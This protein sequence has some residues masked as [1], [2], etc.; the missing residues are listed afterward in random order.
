M[1]DPKKQRSKYRGPRH[2]WQ[3]E[4]LVRERGYVK[5][6]GLKN[7]KEIYKAV[8][9]A[10][11][12]SKHAKKIIRSVNLVQAERETKEFIDRLQRFGLLHK[13]AQLGDVLS[14]T[15]RE[16]LSRRLQQLVYKKGLALTPRQARQFITHG[17]IA[18]H[19]KRVNVPS[20]FV[21]LEE[22]NNIGFY[23]SSRLY[24]AEH[25]ERIKEAKKEHE[26]EKTKEGLKE[27]FEEV[28]GEVEEV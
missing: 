11:R 26:K 23:D 1:G 10:K 28:K 20:Y 5:E 8:S 3:A 19:E 25:P 4:R 16:I 17:H 15:E 18:L 27:S 6:F 22:E 12:L 9:E 7:K 13:D 24:N 2:P 21:S 14:L